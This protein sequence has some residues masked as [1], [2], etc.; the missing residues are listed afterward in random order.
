MTRTEIRVEV[1]SNIKRTADGVPDVRINMWINWAQTL[2]ADWHTFE[3]MRKVY[4]AVTVNA[5]KIYSFPPR[6]KDIYSLTLQDGASSR[7]LVYVPAKEFEQKIPYP[8]HIT[9]GRPAWYVDYGTS[10]ELYRIPDKS[11]TLK[12]RC[13]QYPPDLTSDTEKSTLLRKDALIVAV[14]TMFG[15]LSLR[16]LEDA[17]YWKNEVATPLY[18][19]SLASDHSAED[20]Q[21]VARAFD[22]RPVHI[23]EYWADP[24][25]RSV[26]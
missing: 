19:A 7:K 1:R 15:F 23:G 14:A 18:M 17:T 22:A 11:Y 25:V 5:Q 2:I 21:P 13:S 20:W 8:E 16:E 6:M 26:P 24:L 9:K 4:T 10:F 3:E 12:L